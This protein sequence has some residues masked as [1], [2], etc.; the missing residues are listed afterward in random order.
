VRAQVL[1][2]R[3]APLSGEFGRGL[4]AK[5]FPGLDLAPLADCWVSWQKVS[6]GG[7]VVDGP[8]YM[9]DQPGGYVLRPGLL[10]VTIERKHQAILVSDVAQVSR[11]VSGQVYERPKGQ[12][13]FPRANQPV[14]AMAK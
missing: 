11:N 10:D 12:P 5:Y 2:R 8:G 13:A 7:W 14:R 4:A 1:A 6:R 9:D 3:A